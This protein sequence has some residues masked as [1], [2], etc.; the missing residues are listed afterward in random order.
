[1]SFVA[2]QADRTG[3]GVALGGEP[4]RKRESATFLVRLWKEPTS[5]DGTEGVVRCYMKN[6][7]TGEE[8]YM[9]SMDALASQ[10][11]AQLGGGYLSEGAPEP[12]DSRPSLA[13]RRS[14]EEQS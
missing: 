9:G 3:S 11:L 1:M 14:G 2:D 5:P 6:L 12:D 8:H 10:A 4:I 7:K 13:A